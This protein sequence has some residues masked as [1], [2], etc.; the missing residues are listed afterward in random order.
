MIRKLKIDYRDPIVQ[1]KKKNKNQLFFF[2]TDVI[3]KWKKIC[4]Q[5]C[6]KLCFDNKLYS[7]K[8]VKIN[9]INF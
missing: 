5:Q 6:N 1:Y 3:S 2:C 4:N 8:K 7:K 9:K